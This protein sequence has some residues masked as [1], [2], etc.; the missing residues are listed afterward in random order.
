MLLVYTNTLARHKT[1]SIPISLA[2]TLG[3]TF[4]LY[5]NVTKM[6]QFTLFTITHLNGTYSARITSRLLKFDYRPGIK[7]AATYNYQGFHREIN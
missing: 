3:I 5:S 7:P 6:V 2:T 1:H 4:V